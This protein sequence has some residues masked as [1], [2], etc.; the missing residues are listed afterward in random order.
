M[1]LE[2]AISNFLNWLVKK[3]DQGIRKQLD[4]YKNEQK[5]FNLSMLEVKEDW[6]HPDAF[7]YSLV[8]KKEMGLE[9]I[10][11]NRHTAVAGATGAGKNVTLENIEE[12]RLKA[13][14]PII[15]IDPKGDNQALLRF[16]ELNEY[17]GRKCY[18]F[19]ETYPLSDCCN[20]ILEGEPATIINRIFTCTH[21]S[22]PFSI[23]SN[24]GI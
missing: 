10:D 8:T 4:R 23:T 3:L 5:P 7:G 16:K 12:H 13:G 22:T 11:F 6:Y 18:I 21:Y 9:Q 14:I 15:H 2:L 24:E 19:S 20:P 17:Y 1:A